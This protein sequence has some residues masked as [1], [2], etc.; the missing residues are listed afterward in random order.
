MK[1]PEKPSPRVVDE[2]T[3]VELLTVLLEVRRY[4]PFDELVTRA[5]TKLAR[6]LAEKACAS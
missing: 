5:V 4:D 2:P 1:R 6:R 3:D